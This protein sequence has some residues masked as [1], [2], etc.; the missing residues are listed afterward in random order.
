MSLAA[1]GLNRLR[2]ARSYLRG[3]PYPSNIPL[4]IT[5]ELTN[6]CNLACPMCSRDICD[7]RTGDMDP[8]LLESIVEQ[9]GDLLEAAEVCLGGEPLLYPRLDEV[10]SLLSS[11]GVRSYIQTNA[12]LLEREISEILISCG[13]E[14]A[15]F[16]LDAVTQETYRK[17]HGGGDLSI[18]EKNVRAFRSI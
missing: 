16:S 8:R 3:D 2:L 17:V 5:L 9:A 6:R 14:A 7:A 12:L 11:R 1:K 10:L 4:E 15:V 13:L 18:A